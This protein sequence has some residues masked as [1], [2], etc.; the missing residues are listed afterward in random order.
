MSFF[1]RIGDIT[2]SAMSSVGSF[3]KSDTF[4]TAKTIAKGASDVVSAMRTAAGKV[5]LS[6]PPAGLVNPN[7]GFTGRMTG[8]SR[9]RAGT[10][11]FGD[12]GEASYYKYAQL[13]NTIRYLYGTKS[14][15]KSIAKDR[16]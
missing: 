9:S 5:D 8:T 12:I 15:Y 13:Q 14:R 10:P 4:D 1:S 7:V 16:S 2:S 11:S 3:F 6:E